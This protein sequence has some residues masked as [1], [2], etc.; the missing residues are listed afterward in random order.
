MVLT[1]PVSFGSSVCA[2]HVTPGCRQWP[3]TP[4]QPTSPGPRPVSPA[5]D[6]AAAAVISD[7]ECVKAQGGC[8]LTWHES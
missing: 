6:T 7:E 1:I 8:G 3:A 2:Q 5:D 4:D